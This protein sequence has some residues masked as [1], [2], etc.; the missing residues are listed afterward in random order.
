[1][2]AWRRPSPHPRSMRAPRAE[3]PSR[4]GRV[5][6][7]LSSPRRAPDRP[8]ARHT[9]S[10][11]RPLSSRLSLSRRA[12]TQYHP[13]SPLALDH[14]TT[15]DR[16]QRRSRHRRRDA[17]PPNSPSRF[18]QAF[19]TYVGFGPHPGLPRHAPL[20]TDGA[21]PR[22]CR[23]CLPSGC[24]VVD[25]GICPTPTLQLAV[26][27][28]GARGGISITAGHN[29]AAWNALKFVRR[30]RPLPDDRAGRRT[31]RHLSTR[32][33]SRRP[34]GTASGPRSA[35]RD[36]IAAPPRSCSSGAF[37]VRRDPTRAR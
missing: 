14:E 33:S 17:S 22:S 15:Q 12:L 31:A 27:W 28:L 34:R 19:G 24:E 16:H 18:A 1:M 10:P 3:R 32:A 5:R 2:P 35:T 36:A 25:L 4:R 29:P 37:D 13:G 20:G 30:R 7:R 11:G 23:A 26:R 21:R 8:E 6:R 9:S